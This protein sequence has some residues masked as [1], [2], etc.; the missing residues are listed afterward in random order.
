MRYAL[1]SFVL[2]ASVARAVIVD[3]VAVS[4]GNK[5][6]THSEI[7]RQIRIAAFLNDRQ[8]DLGPQARREAAQ[9]LIDQKLIAREMDLGRFPRRGADAA[10]SMLSAYVESEFSGDEAVMK[11]HAE[12]VGIT[13]DELG[14]E[15]VWQADFLTFLNL[16]FRPAVDV[17][18]ADVRK[19]FDDM[20]AP[21]IAPDQREAAFVKLRPQIEE[22]LTMAGSDR[23]LDIWL[24]DQRQRTRIE[25]V[26]KSLMEPAPK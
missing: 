20:F 10:P 14:A 25:Y 4:V 11:S 7:D 19:Y 5:V 26:D 17:S 16:R 22:Q 3:G 12:T 2:C 8:P 1:L 15:L 9:R 6:I 18:E 13:P 24:K 23:A 21:N